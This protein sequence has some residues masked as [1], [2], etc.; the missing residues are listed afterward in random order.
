LIALLQ[1]DAIDVSTGVE[2]QPGVKDPEK[3]DALFAAVRASRS[4]AEAA[5]EGGGV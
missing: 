4:L 3:L 5:Q 1:P 2:A